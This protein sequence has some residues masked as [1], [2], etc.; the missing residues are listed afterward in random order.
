[1]HPAQIEINQDRHKCSLKTLKNQER[2]SPKTYKCIGRIQ[3]KK[4]RHIKG[5][6]IDK[7]KIPRE[8]HNQREKMSYFMASSLDQNNLKRALIGS[9]PGYVTSPKFHASDY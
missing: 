7:T 9:E 6:G 2:L 4:K 5:I 1:M 8:R 3:Y